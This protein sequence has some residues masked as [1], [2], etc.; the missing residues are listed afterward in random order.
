ML[1]DSVT[2]YKLIH[3]RFI[4][5]KGN[6]SHGK[7]IR[8]TSLWNVSAVLLPRSAFC[9]RKFR[10]FRNRTAPRFIAL[11]CQD[12]Y[13]PFTVKHAKWTVSHSVPTFAHFFVRTVIYAN[14]VKKR[15]RTGKDR[16]IGKF[17]CRKFT[18]SGYTRAMKI[19]GEFVVKDRVILNEQNK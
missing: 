16:T 8:S 1:E 5:T 19:T 15:S 6:A 14:E 18:D 12:V 13:V 2:L 17:M 7:T 10:R 9:C 11:N 3:Q 4:M